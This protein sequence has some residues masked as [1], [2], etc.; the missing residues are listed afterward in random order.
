MTSVRARDKKES[1]PP[2]ESS[3]LTN[4]HSDPTQSNAMP[5]NAGRIRSLL[6]LLVLLFGLVGSAGGIVR[7]DDESLIFTPLGFDHPGSALKAA[8][9]DAG[10]LEIVVLDSSTGKP[11]PCRVNV[12]GPDGNFYQPAE[13]SLSLYSLTGEWPKHGKGNRTGKAPFRYFGRFFYSPGTTLI[14]VPKGKIRIE[15]W[16]GFEYQP[17]VETVAIEAGQTR[18]VSISLTRATTPQQ[19]GY[20]SGDTHLHFPRTNPADDDAIFTLLAA[21]DIRY[22]F[23]LGYNDPPGPYNA[24]RASLEYP[25]L[26]GLGKGS[27]ASRG[28][29]HLASG[30][31]YRSSTYGHLN[32]YFRDDLVNEGQNYNANDWPA[33]GLVGRE[34]RRKG[35]FAIHA[36]G[37]YAQEIYANAVQGDI[38]AVELLQFGVYR[39]IELADWYAFLNAGFRLPCVGASDFP[40]CRKL[41]DCVTYVERDPKGDGPADWLKR[42]GNGRSFVTTG[43]ILLLEVDGRKPG[44]RIA[45]TEKSSQKISVRVLSPVAPVETVQII[46]NGRVVAESKTP[47]GGAV[48]EW[49]TFDTRIELNESSWIAARAFGKTKLGAPD[50]ESHSN[51]VFVDLDGKAP[52]DR[53]SVDRLIAKLDEQMAKN[54]AR[55]FAEKAKLLDYFQKSR[56]ILLK[57]RSSGG[58][59]A[60]GVPPTWLAE[61]AEAFDPTKKAHDDEQLKVFLKPLPALTPSEALKTFETLPGF[62]LELVASEPLVHSPVAAAFDEDGSLYVAEM[63]DYPYKPR[64]GSEPLGAVR[65]LR[66]TDGDGEFDTSDIVADKLMWPTG[67][68][69]WKGGVF[70][71]A[72]PDIWYF[73]DTNG[74][75]ITDV[76]RKVFTGFGTNNEQ[77]GVNN[78][79]FGLD[80]KIYGS[81]S[82]NGGKVHRVDLPNAPVIDVEHADFR[83]DPE[84][85]EFEAITGTVQFG[86][87]FDDYGNR[88]LCSES[89]P[90]LHAVLPMENLARN[91]FLPVS[92]AIANVANAPEPIHRISPLE[93]WRQIRSSRRIAHGERSA[94]SAGA[95]H[96][97][98]DAAAG[99]TIYRGTAYPES[100][101][102]DAFVG[103]AQNNLIHRMKLTPTGPTFKAATVDGDKEFVRSSDNWFRPVNLINAP[104]GTLYALDMSREVI[105]AIHIPLDVVKHLDLRRGRDQGRIYRIAPDGFSRKKSPQLSKATTTELVSMLEHPDGWWRDTAHRLLFERQDATAIER[106]NSLASGAKSDVSRIHALWSLHGQKALSDET[107]VKSL[108]DRSPHVVEHTVRLAEPRLETLPNLVEKIAG[109]ASH[110]ELRVRFQVALSLG[111][112]RNPLAVEALARIAERDANDSWTRIAVLASAGNMPD[113]LFAR[114]AH[115]ETFRS[116]ETGAAFLDQL[117]EVL[118]A[119][120]RR[121]EVARALEILAGESQPQPFV[122][123]L[124]LAIGRGMSRSGGHFSLADGSQTPSGRLISQT[125]DRAAAESVDEKLGEATRLQAIAIMGCAPFERSRNVLS[126][127]LDPKYSQRLQLA[128]LRAFSGYGEPEIASLL[129]ERNRSMAP[130]VRVEAIDVLL[131]RE[132][133]TLVLLQA[134]KDG[135]IDVGEIE[136]TRRPALAKH[137]NAEIAAIAKKLFT[138]PG[139]G[140]SQA[141]D[142]MVSYSPALKLKGDAK[143][144]GEVFGKLCATCHRVGNVGYSVGPDL[145]A[146]QFRESDALLTHIVEPNRFVPPNYVQYIV[147]DRSGRVYSG[148]IVSET[149]S[150]MTLRRAEGAEDTILRSQID[151]LSSTSKSLMPEGLVA[152][153]SHQELADLVAFLLSAHR[154]TA[155]SGRLDIGT[156]AGAIEPEK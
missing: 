111:A 85:L 141:T 123:R 104:D 90:L 69:P 132:S 139:T 44:D 15:A 40:A 55:K 65:R 66:D 105:E 33:F 20:D 108:S 53:A 103:D 121:D 138:G 64:P 72:P 124:V 155:E 136:L 96:H 153:L 87:T 107:L 150:S 113:A 120:N 99:V 12:V 149:P 14:D 129:L 151:E 22:G 13:N 115:S 128:A 126:A 140:S 110:D 125:L 16:K 131:S 35:G 1:R 74:D 32:L 148:L 154:G 80:H 42:A 8:G 114:L 142:L 23:T 46:V 3:A 67:V 49:Y 117:A 127:L 17:L 61:D 83:F 145:S 156:E 63:I 25:Q 92:Q 29:Y 11:T 84:T 50:A 109:L 2:N 6:A 79:T 43:P 45:L 122:R 59:P 76:R 19:I 58:L 147:S 88:F 30:Q 56:D 38:D 39:G 41:G 100:F 118:G 102:G 9:A 4:P 82:T 70:V 146:T 143:R 31:E 91:P 77:G 47:S 81:S 5:T 71:A 28:G 133:W 95:S 27:V 48:R 68:A 135:R 37:G 7:G 98:I 137:K 93:R 86:T 119:R 78:L 18:R 130:V 62:H 24:V 89:R 73:K 112:T 106:L 60:A 134:L 54:R 52:Y 101:R 10:H 94:D 57:I 144:G 152:K 34:T 26:Q 36:H 21:E 75:H 97:V 116:S 51:P